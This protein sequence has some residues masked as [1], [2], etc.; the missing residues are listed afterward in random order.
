MHIQDKLFR[1]RFRQPAAIRFAISV[2]LLL[3]GMALSLPAGTLARALEAHNGKNSFSAAKDTLEKDGGEL[4]FAENKKGK[5]RP[6]F[7]TVHL[8][9]GIGGTV[10]DFSELDPLGI[11]KGKFSLPISFYTYIPF[12][13]ARPGFYILGGSDV[14]LFEPN[15]YAFRALLLYQLPVRILL[16]AGASR[17]TFN[18]EESVNVEATQTQGLLAIGINLSPHR[19]DLLMTVPVNSRMKTN[20]EGNNYSIRTA[21]IQVSLLIS[22]R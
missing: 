9:F 5:A 15:N 1:F 16:G 13:R 3:S 4:P 12:Q 7:E 8:V 22:L 17:T 18:A 10:T 21:G 19:V 11:S 2:F 20:F 14:D 6:R